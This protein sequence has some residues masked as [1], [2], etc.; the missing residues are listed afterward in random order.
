M[1]ALRRPSTVEC[2]EVLLEVIWRARRT[3]LPLVELPL[4]DWGRTG[5]RLRH[6]YRRLARPLRQGLR[7]RWHREDAER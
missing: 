6:L 3:C 2:W 5:H 4:E 1:V 7:L